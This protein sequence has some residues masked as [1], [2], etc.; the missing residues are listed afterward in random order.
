MVDFGVKWRGRCG[1]VAV[2]ALFENNLGGGVCLLGFGEE[3]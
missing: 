3:M 1:K 2:V